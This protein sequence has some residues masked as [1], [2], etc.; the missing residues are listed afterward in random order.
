MK[1][2]KG[3]HKSSFFKRKRH[4]SQRF[5]VQWESSVFTT[6]L[7]AAKVSV[8]SACSPGSSKSYLSTVARVWLQLINQ[9]QRPPDI[10]CRVHS[11]FT[12]NTNWSMIT[13]LEREARWHRVSLP[14]GVGWL[15]HFEI[16]WVWIIYWIYNRFTKKQS[17]SRD[18]L[19]GSVALINAYLSWGLLSLP[20][21]YLRKDSFI[22]V[23]IQAIFTWIWLLWPEIRSIR[24]FFLF[25]A[26]GRVS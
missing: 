3:L 19:V 6:D 26:E 4:Q 9:Q 25:L 8:W 14:S 10:D 16:L 22:D 24:I 23:L 20:K 18:L 13:V 17:H 2:L 5:R 11:L 15:C 12:F 21:H 1:H 7:C